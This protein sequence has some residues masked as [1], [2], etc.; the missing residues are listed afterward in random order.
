MTSSGAE[1]GVLGSTADTDEGRDS[2]PT[3]TRPLNGVSCT[4][5]DDLLP[6]RKKRTRRLTGARLFARIGYACSPSRPGY[7]TTGRSTHRA[8]ISL[9]YTC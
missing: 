5:H 3:S 9:A 2:P 7:G 6:E 8:S 1:V 4:P